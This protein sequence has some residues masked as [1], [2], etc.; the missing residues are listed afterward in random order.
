MFIVLMPKEQPSWQV[1]RA[2]IEE[3]HLPCTALPNRV[4]ISAI[5]VRQG[6]R[7]ARPSEAPEG[8]N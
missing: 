5:G 3:R 8:S 7:R 1:W 2:T 4:R 6:L